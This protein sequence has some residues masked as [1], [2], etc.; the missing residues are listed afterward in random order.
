MHYCAQEN[1]FV[2]DTQLSAMLPQPAKKPQHQN[3]INHTYVVILLQTH[4]AIVF[5]GY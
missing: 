1:V 2:V 5:Y 4:L 3:A